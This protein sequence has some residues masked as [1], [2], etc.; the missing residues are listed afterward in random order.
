MARPQCDTPLVILG[1]LEGT[2]CRLNVSLTVLVLNSVC[3]C[4]SGGF[5]FLVQGCT[6]SFLV[7]KN[8]HFDWPIL[9][10]NIGQDKSTE[11]LPFCPHFTVYEPVLAEVYIWLCIRILTGYG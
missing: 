7:L 8:S 4:I 2:L 5:E 1:L 6:Q 3:L 9:F 10:G 11:L